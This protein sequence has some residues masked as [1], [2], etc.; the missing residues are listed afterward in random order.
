MSTTHVFT[1]QGDSGGPLVYKNDRNWEL[2]GITSWGFGCAKRNRPGVFTDVKSKKKMAGKH[3]PCTNF[4]AI[5]T[6]LIG[7]GSDQVRLQY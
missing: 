6:R 5:V 1:L 2:V 3:F 7:S 4:Y